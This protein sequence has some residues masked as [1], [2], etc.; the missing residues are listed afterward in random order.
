MR[1]ITT[2]VEQLSEKDVSYSR[3]AD[4]VQ[5]ISFL[6]TLSACPDRDEDEI[7]PEKEMAGT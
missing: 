5:A 4:E 6:S 7:Y 2:N 3:L 1:R